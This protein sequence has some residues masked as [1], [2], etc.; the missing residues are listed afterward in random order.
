MKK[1]NV[2]IIGQGRSGRDIH[3]LYFK[4]DKNNYFNVKYIVEADEF[5]REKAKGE[6]EGC[7]V[8]EGYEELFGIED[9]DVVVNASYSEMHYDITLDLIEHGFNV[10]CEKPFGKTKYESDDL[11]KR[12]K[13]KGVFLG[14]FQQSFL[15]PYYVFAKEAYDSGKLG[16]IM[17]VSVKF[18]GFARRWDWQTLL[19]K[20]AGGLYNTG[21]H[22]IGLALGFLDF[23]PETRLVYSKL[24]RAMTSGDGDDF[25]KLILTAPGKPVVDIEVSSNDAYSDFH[26][27][28]QGTR[29][30]LK[31]SIKSYEMT[32]IVD[33]ENPERPVSDIFIED[34]ER[35]PAYCSEEL[36]KHTE[37]GEHNG[38]PFSVGSPSYYEDVYYALTENRPMRVTAEMAAE[39]IKIIAE[40][41]ASNPLPVIY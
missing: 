10:I 32:Y 39:V 15:A 28:L 2:A 22:P 18:N 13:E 26:I 37:S 17:Q 30:T 29:G 16:R 3:G 5:R 12:A 8:F 35:N 20:C 38:D 11:I 7:T 9:I 4:S 6:Y 19:K 40:A 14:V 1:L 41:H 27:K 21:P 24:D 34:A 25:A 33:G 31:T 23:D 36:V